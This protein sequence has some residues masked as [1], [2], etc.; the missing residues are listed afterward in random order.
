V[1]TKY[2][3]GEYAIL[4]KDRRRSTSAFGSKPFFP[5]GLEIGINWIP[6]LQP[7]V[8][9]ITQLKNGLFYNYGYPPVFV[10][11]DDTIA[12]P[13]VAQCRNDGMGLYTIKHPAGG[14]YYNGSLRKQL[15]FKSPV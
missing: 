9:F 15:I 5:R 8:Y 12:E 13:V 4:G 6:P 10:P 7:C 2:P 14:P 1:K 11:P 3:N